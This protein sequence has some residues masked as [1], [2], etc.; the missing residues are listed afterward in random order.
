[1]KINY[2]FE[3]TS[4]CSPDDYPYS[5]DFDYGHWAMSDLWFRTYRK[6]KI[7]YPEINFTPHNNTHIW[8]DPVKYAELTNGG[9]YYGGNCKYAN[10]SLIIENPDNKKYIVFTLMDKIIDFYVKINNWDMENC[11]EI[12]T[13]LGAAERLYYSYEKCNVNY[14]PSIGSFACEISNEKSIEKIYSEK[15]PRIFS[16]KLRFIGNIYGIRVDLKENGKLE[17]INKNDCRID[18]HIDYLRELDKYKV[19]ISLNSVAEASSRDFEIMGLGSL[20][21]RCVFNTSKF[22]NPLIPDY[23]YAAINIYDHSD[24]N[25]I[26][27]AFLE[28]YEY[29][30]SNPEFL[31][32]VSQNGRKWYEENVPREKAS[33]ILVDQILDLNKLI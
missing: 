12:I 22:H 20:N 30:K 4:D 27:D 18:Q 31:D 26:A 15:N 21:L 28:K 5:P 2:Y 10:A 23:H 32:F 17:I 11:V 8:M 14:T 16:E 13:S 33:S 6:L 25:K 29:I 24:I 19:N 7:K 1:M 3:W 9:K